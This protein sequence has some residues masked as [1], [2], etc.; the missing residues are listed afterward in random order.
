M[1]NLKRDISILY[2]LVRNSYNNA[3][4]HQERL[5][6]FYKHQADNYDN[7]RNRMLWGRLPLIRVCVSFLEKKRHHNNLV[8]IDLGGGTGSNVEIMDE[9]FD[10]SHFKKIYIVDLCPSL[11]KIAEQR[12][13]E[14]G[15]D[16]VEVVC[17]DACTFTSDIHADLV[18]FSYSLSMIPEYL[19]A[20]DNA[21][22]LLKE[23]GIVGVTDFYVS[24]KYDTL[25]RQMNWLTR[26]FYRMWFDIDGIDLSPERRTYLEKTFHTLHESNSYGKI[27]Y[28][29]LKAPYYV[30]IGCKNRMEINSQN[31]TINKNKTPFL[32]PPTFLYHQSWEDPRED[33]KVLDLKDTDVCLTLTSGG[34]NTLNLLI[35]GAKQVYSV[36]I[37]P[38][39]TALLELK[40]I[41]MRHLK[42]EDFWKLFG[43]GKHENMDEIYYK[44]LA[45]FL[46]DSSR[47]FWD[48][49]KYYFHHGL[50]HHGS[51][52][53]ISKYLHYFFKMT[54][55]QHQ[56]DRIVKAST[57]E[58][59][60][61]MWN[62]LW[63]SRIFRN[64]TLSS[65][66][67][68]LFQLIALNK[69]V[70]WFAGGIPV[71]QYD[72]ILEDDTSVVDY[73]VRCIS[74]V[75]LNSHLRTD[76]YFYWNLLTGSYTHKCCPNYLKK[77]YF[78]VLRDNLD[79]LVIVNDTF[80][81]ELCRRKY[82]KIILMDHADWQTWEE[83]E[84][85]SKRLYEHMNEGGKLILRSASYEP[86]YIE[87]LRNVGFKVQCV[88]RI[89]E[90]PYLDRVNMYASFYVCI[91]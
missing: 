38:A 16:N 52:G 70:A 84:N 73:F 66:L 59:Q 17:A 22:K 76:N 31:V 58:L 28:T 1:D 39:Q 45:P 10:I 48:K 4:S 51:M 9:L 34:C 27:P 14:K 30:W 33:M 67:E 68:Q 65:I 47:H 18:T 43:K 87:Q 15:W 24:K 40:C 3:S 85:L 8:W 29:P 62:K 55:M 35:E 5:E 54:G 6:Q 26:N 41:A 81:H 46:S 61:S 20:I 50:Y 2:Y 71:K 91:R 90:N 36:D 21:S 75:F 32:F 74:G 69:T 19:D 82:D 13:K 80:N 37:N 53:K 42:Y 25:N 79:K 83:T 12:K 72:L 56:V 60:V 23:C 63:K 78:D 64:A 77:R 44:D 89:D 86:P 88:S 57:M 11:C 49:K 7:F